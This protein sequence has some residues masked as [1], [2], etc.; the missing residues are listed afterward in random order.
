[1]R[2][3]EEWLCAQLDN[4]SLKPELRTKYENELNEIAKRITN[5]RV[6]AAAEAE[7]RKIKENEDLMAALVEREK[8]LAKDMDMSYEAWST[9]AKSLYSIT[10][11]YEVVSIASGPGKE[12]I[13]PES[14]EYAAR[15]RIFKLI[16][17]KHYD[18][19]VRGRS[20]RYIPPIKKES[21]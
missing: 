18:H 11:N 19:F 15:E 7:K 20:F 8:A 21:A 17:Y 1:M 16:Q 14:S 13:W 3:R 12:R 10:D 4:E 5:D 9:L 6:R 2:S